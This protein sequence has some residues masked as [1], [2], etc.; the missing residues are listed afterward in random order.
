MSDHVSAEI[1]RLN[2][3]LE[4]MTD[5]AEALVLTVRNLEHCITCAIEVDGA[6]SAILPQG[7]KLARK[8]TSMYDNLVQEARDD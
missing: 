4:L 5:I 2:H 1:T 8:I 3:R 7:Q 6:D